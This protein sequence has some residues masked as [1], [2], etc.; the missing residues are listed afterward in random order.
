MNYVST[1]VGYS[2][3]KKGPL[4]KHMKF[5]SVQAMMNYV[6][7]GPVFEGQFLSCDLSNGKSQ[8]FVIR[9]G[10]PFPIFNNM[11]LI[12]TVENGETYVLLSANNTTTYNTKDPFNFNINEIKDIFKSSLTENPMILETSDG[13]TTFVYVKATTYFRE[14]GN[15]G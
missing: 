12:T 9:G 3:V 11:E 7:N 14:V 6:F 15:I 13:D 1:P 8:P 5:A 10:H 2:M 4:D